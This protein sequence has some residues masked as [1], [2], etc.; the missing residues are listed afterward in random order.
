MPAFLQVHIPF[1]LEIPRT[2][3]DVYE[4]YK[5]GLF[6]DAKFIIPA[7]NGAS[8][9]TTGGVFYQDFTKLNQT[10]VLYEA[11]VHLGWNFMPW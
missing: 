7:L 10:K 2:G 9:I 6:S 3:L 11:S 1:S 8:I 5:I 4:N